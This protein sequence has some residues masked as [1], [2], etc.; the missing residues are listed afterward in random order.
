MASP[1]L[2]QWGFINLV[3]FVGWMVEAESRPNF[4]ELKR[5]FDKFSREPMRYLS[6]EVDTMR[7]REFD[8]N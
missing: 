4:H 6:V 1:F 2:Y 5:D 8:I 3:V 7:E